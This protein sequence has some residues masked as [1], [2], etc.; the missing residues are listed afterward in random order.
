MSILLRDLR[1]PEDYTALA[2]LLNT[3]GSEPTTA[4]RLRE[5]D[6]KL[7]EVGH[8]YLDENGLLAGYDRTRKVAVT[9]QDEIVGYI[10]SWRAPWTEPGYL[11]NTLIVAEDYRRQGIGQLLLQHAAGWGEK[12]GADTLVTEIWDDSPESLHFAKRTG[13]AIERHAFQSVLT[14]NKVD[15][16]S[17]FDHE[18]FDKL[19]QDGIRFI[20]LAEEPDEE[21]EQKLY[22]LYEETLKDIPG[23]TG[24]VPVFDQWRKWYLMAE[25]Y[26][27][28]QVLLAVHDGKHVGVSNVLYN[29]LTNGMYHEYTSV[30][31][32]Y[33]GRKIALGLKMK[34]ILLAKERHAA[35]LRT[36]NDSLNEPILRINRRLGYEAL[37]GSYRLIA[38][39]TDVRG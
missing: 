19:A 4:E 15:P 25:G 28:E 6:S 38:K 18:L 31:R 30:A 1:L 23:Y 34:A 29:P 11:N 35:Y 22:R 5:D 36:D 10:N 3:H 8:T 13:F 26:S 24:E 2:E 16:D 20:T 14:L 33:R 21:G 37:R 9:E 32:A 7:Y 27:P 17:A 12:V 39:V